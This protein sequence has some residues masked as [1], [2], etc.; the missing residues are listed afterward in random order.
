MLPDGSVGCLVEEGKWDSNMAGPDGFTIAF[1]R[2]GIDWL[3]DGQDV[4]TE[5]RTIDD[6][7]ESESETERL[8]TLDGLPAE[9]DS[10]SPGLYVVRTPSSS[11]LRVV[12]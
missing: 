11:S 8:F 4:A 3:T 7:H 1:Y 9:K 5:V 10:A 2:F 12:R 6:R